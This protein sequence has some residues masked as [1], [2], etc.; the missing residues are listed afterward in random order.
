V[1]KLDWQIFIVSN[2][3]AI[4]SYWGIPNMWKRVNEAQTSFVAELY[5]IP[6]SFMVIGVIVAVLFNYALI[7]SIFKKGEAQGE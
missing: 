1:S 2:M 4:F 6:I 5:Y 3:T 7:C